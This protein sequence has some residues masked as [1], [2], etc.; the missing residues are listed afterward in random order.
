MSILSAPTADIRRFLAQ[1]FPEESY[2]DIQQNHDLLIGQLMEFKQEAITDLC[3]EFA[4][5]DIW[6]YAEIVSLLQTSA[7]V[8]R[9]EV[10]LYAKV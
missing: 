8:V 9:L 3:R 6:T 2:A 5:H 4:K 10:A 1:V 7:Q